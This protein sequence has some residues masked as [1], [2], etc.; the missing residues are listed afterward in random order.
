[1]Y[2]YIMLRTWRLR[3]SRSRSEMRAPTSPWS[4]M[5]RADIDDPTALWIRSTWKIK[6]S[7]QIY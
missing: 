7:D 2:L 1:M 3:S 5:G 4:T 6:N